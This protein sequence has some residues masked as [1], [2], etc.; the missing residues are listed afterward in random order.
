LKKDTGKRVCLCFRSSTS[1]F[2]QSLLGTVLGVTLVTDEL[3]IN[4]KKKEREEAEK[5]KGVRIEVC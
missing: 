1:C 4:L 5:R 2:T 3:W